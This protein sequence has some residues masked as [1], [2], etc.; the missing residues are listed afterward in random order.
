MRGYSCARMADDED[1]LWA[2]VRDPVTFRALESYTV[3]RYPK[4]FNHIL[5]QQ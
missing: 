5:M 3:F 4:L 1:D 2:Q